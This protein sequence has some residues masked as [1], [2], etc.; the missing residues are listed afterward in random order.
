MISVVFPGQGS[1]KVGMGLD[2]FNKFEH[3]KHIFNYADEILNYISKVCKNQ[4]YI[5]HFA[6]I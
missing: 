6:Y 2:F 5:N 1:Q 4:N 3:V